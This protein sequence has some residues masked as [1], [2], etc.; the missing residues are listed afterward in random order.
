MNYGFYKSAFGGNLI[1]PE[2]FNRFLF[3]AQTYLNNLT[4]SRPIPPQYE[5]N[6]RFALCEMAQCYYRFQN[7]LLIESEN[8]DGYSVTYSKSDLNS[9]LYDIANLYLGESGLLYKGEV[10]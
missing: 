7:G 3:K 10:L 6:A 8:T 9:M 5:T 1:P 2:L 4:K